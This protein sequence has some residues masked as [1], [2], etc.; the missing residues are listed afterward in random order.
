MDKQLAALEAILFVANK[1]L[2]VKDLAEL[3][4][5]KTED[6]ET[7]LDA[8]ALYYQAQKAGLQLIRSG[9]KYQLVTSADTAEV[10][11]KFLADEMTG[12]LSRP[13]LESLTIIAY[14]GPIAKIDLDR[15]RGVNCALILRNL[16]MRGLIEEEL[17]KTK[18]ETYYRVSLDFIRYLGV[19]RVEELPDYERLHQ[20]EGLN[21]LL[22]RAE[23]ETL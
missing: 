2:A 16:L 4:K 23:T 20:D 21:Q 7:S 9:S 10:V 3:L 8:L 1:P 12:E 19:N 6:I 5:I 22:A 18:N 11:R 15:I 13:S 14:R 17:D